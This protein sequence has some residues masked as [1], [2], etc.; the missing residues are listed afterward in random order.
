M[1]HHQ[2]VGLPQ[3]LSSKDDGLGPKDSFAAAHSGIIPAGSPPPPADE[4]ATRRNESVTIQPPS[5][6]GDENLP[7]RG[8]PKDSVIRQRVFHP[9]LFAAYPVLALLAYNVDWL[10]PQQALR[11]AILSIGVAGLLLI[12]LA[13]FLPPWPPA[14]APGPCGDLDP[15]SSPRGTAAAGRLLLD[16]RRLRPPGH[17]AICVRDGQ[18]AFPPLLAGPW[19]LCGRRRPLH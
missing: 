14:A 12:V 2:A 5:P 10:R 13:R 11:A 17:S 15:P 3:I 1:G 16:R 4:V 9:L 6:Q 8:I 19:L 7:L 18:R